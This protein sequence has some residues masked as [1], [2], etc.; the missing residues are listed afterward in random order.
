[1]V[2]QQEVATPTRAERRGDTGQM[3]PRDPEQGSRSRTS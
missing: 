2:E 3:E 1:M